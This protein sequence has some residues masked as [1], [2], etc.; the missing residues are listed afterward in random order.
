MP[1]GKIVGG[2]RWEKVARVGE[3]GDSPGLNR[4]RDA[5]VGFSPEPRSALG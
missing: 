4:A 1:L 5:C 3:S 2:T